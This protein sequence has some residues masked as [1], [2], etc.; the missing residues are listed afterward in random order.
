M[1]AERDQG[2]ECHK[3]VQALGLPPAALH[4]PSA[5]HTAANAR[6]AM[7]VLLLPSF[8]CNRV[9]VCGESNL[10]PLVGARGV[11]QTCEHARFQRGDY[12]E[13]VFLLK[14]TAV[15]SPQPSP[16]QIHKPLRLTLYHLH[17]SSFTQNLSLTHFPWCCTPSAAKSHPG[18]FFL[19]LS[20]FS[21]NCCSPLASLRVPL[22]CFIPFFHWPLYCEP[23]CQVKV[24]SEDYC[25]NVK[26][27]IYVNKKCSG[28]HT[29]VPL[30]RLHVSLIPLTICILL[31]HL[32]NESLSQHTKVHAASHAPTQAVIKKKALR[33]SKQR[34][35]PFSSL[36]LNA[37]LLT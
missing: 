23:S 26:Y 9:V 24:P 37:P 32:L 17:A 1:W 15:S 12:G 4:Q 3:S 30:S 20:Q 33:A 7:P 14:L 25:K 21:A 31:H 34:T 35:C 11:L 19:S 6:I 36:R 5:R 18:P 2:G 16:A 22:P 8:F 27:V 29:S 28:A 13:I 10:P